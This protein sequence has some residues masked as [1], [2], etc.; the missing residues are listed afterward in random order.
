[1][2]DSYDVVVVGSGPAG[3]AAAILFGRSGLRVA[4]LEAHKD[5][6]HYKRLC[7]HSI[8][9]S[10]LPTLRKLGL[11]TAF[12]ELGAVRHHENLWTEYGWTHE[13]RTRPHG[14]NI[15][16][17]S[18]DPLMRSTA[19]AVPCVDLLM[20]ARVRELTTDRDRRVSGV[21]ADIGGDRHHITSRLVVG[22]DGHT[23]KV[24]DLAGLPAQVS[25]GIRFGYL[26][27]YRN[28]GVPVGQ[29]GAMWFQ[30]PDVTYY[31]CNDEGVTV[32]VAFP[33]KD[34]LDEFRT[35]R[36]AALLR[37]FAQ[38]P[39]GPDM[40][41]AE[42]VSDVIGTPDYPS[43]TRKR[44]VG[45]GVALI[46]DAAMVGDP[47]WGTGCGWAF[48]SADWLADA[49]I[50]A[51]RAGTNVDAATRRYQWRHRRALLPN[52]LINIDFSRKR[53]LNPLQ[54]MLYRS[55]PHNQK[56]ADRLFAVGTRST[57]P[58]AA[59]DPVLLARAAVTTATV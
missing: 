23:S 38:L 12:E 21:V 58:L 14:Y 27:G 55:A 6:S 33:A 51:L 2:T 57:S 47:L 41:N 11:D 31:F 54:R 25:S 30:Q 29:T 1:M 16:R 35:D 53:T 42:R 45:P 37:M 10:A 13:D 22:A 18:L 39:D 40:S 34:R 24:A 46:G 4:L 9:S 59:L 44:I 7:T 17:Q 19:A 26:A 8:R 50:G 36:E 49:T 32:L 20:G 52:Q 56:V 48:Q 43:I 15:R 3:C 5:F 28:V